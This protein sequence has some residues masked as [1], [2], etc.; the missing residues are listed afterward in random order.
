[1]VKLENV[2]YWYRD[3]GEMVLRNLS[4]EI[5]PGEA[6]CIM[7]RNGSG[8]STLARLIAGLLK[9]KRG[10]I[11]VN[12]RTSADETSD[13]DVGILFQNPDN[14]MI[15]TLVEKEIA[16]A[17]ENQAVPQK[18]MEKAVSS[19]AERLGVT[20]L[21][22][23]L[24][25]D[26]S[27]G[28][29]QRVALAS[30][31][32]QRPSVLVLDE[33]DA[34]LDEKGRR[35]LQ[36]ELRQIHRF[37]SDLV[38]MRITQDP[39]VATT[40]P[41]LIV[42]EA[43]EVVADGVPNDIMNDPDVV[44]RAALSFAA[45]EDRTLT[46]PAALT[47]IKGN[48]VRRVAQTKLERTAFAYPR[49]PDVL[50]QISLQ[51]QSGQIL[52]LV[53]PTGAGKSS[54]GLL[55]CGLLQPTAGTISYLDGSGESIEKEHLKG[56]VAA[57]LQQPERQFFLDNC[58]KEIAF[59]PSNLGRQITSEEIDGFF[60]MAGL[61]PAQFADRDPFTLSTGE[62]RRLAFAAVLSMRP[63]VVVFD[64]P[65]AGLDQE[66]VARFLQ[67]AASLRD[68]GIAQLVI[69]HDGDVIRQLADRVLY[70]RAGNDLLALEPR[71]FF[72]NESY[73]GVV[74]SPAPFS[75]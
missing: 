13:P 70:L 25:S 35:I 49:T 60:E 6:V 40:Y 44:Y 61:D 5:R 24:T 48:G 7:G 41:R 26:L 30:I 66:G 19:I 47:D 57:L 3:E 20:H 32:I 37:N 4:L 17:L 73:A 71:E 50:N 51:I 65:T 18:Q 31:M 59:G 29:K 53:G 15:A 23:R 69:S 72:E 2:T 46:L 14:Q 64:E 67:L 38:E 9:P 58:S 54:L 11:A 55:I 74:S 75:A 56:Q 33:P 68:N 36:K 27:G 16:F 12:G 39:S 42:L 1:M 10:S 28:E 34:F 8:K 45:F 63:S 52:G 21:L 22:P 43:G 62:K